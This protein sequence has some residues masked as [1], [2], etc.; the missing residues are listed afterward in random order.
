MT[1]PPGNGAE[2]GFSLVEVLV[3]LAIVSLGL[4]TL[5]GAMSQSAR[6]VADAATRSATLAHAQ[7]QLDA[8][9][10]GEPLTPGASHGTYA[11]G[12]RWSLAVGEVADADAPLPDAAR[13]LVAVLEA[14]DPSG[15]RLVR[16]KTLKLQAPP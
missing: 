12:A 13:G 11:N 15:R 6:Q 2:A 10:H 4:V 16:L 14:F 5:Y 1:E 8:L 3:A 7:S 9:G